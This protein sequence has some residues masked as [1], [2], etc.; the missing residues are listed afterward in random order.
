MKLYFRSATLLAGGLMMEI[1]CGCHRASDTV[2]DRAAALVPA[3]VQ[4]QIV[5]SKSRIETEEV[6]GTVRAKL[7]A[8]IEAKVS[9][10]IEKM[11]AVPGQKV[12]TGELLAELDAREIQARVDQARAVYQQAESDWKRLAALWDQK[13]LSQAEY[14]TAKARFHVAE[15]TL[16]EAET[17]LDYTKV[18][19]P[20]E[21]IIT[22]KLVDVGDLATPGKPLLEMED[23]TALRLEADVPEA[24]VDNVKIADRLPVRIGSIETPME[25]VVS[26]IAPAADPNSRT[27]LVKLDLPITPGLRA[28]QFGRTRMPVGKTSALCVPA[29]AVFERGQLEMVFVA[30]ESHAHLRLVKTGK[31][32]GDE[33]EIASGLEAGESIV[34]TGGDRLIDGQLLSLR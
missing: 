19:A 27:F 7:R 26:E 8:S 16:L 32:I 29:S 20:F 2:A 11:H 18:T 34:V 23:S 25:G 28:G 31:H 21:G 5:E 9:G 10:R 6:V 1:L 17:L 3:T 15:A 14:D 33:L 30:S 22:R 12:A 4:V 13:V 24:I